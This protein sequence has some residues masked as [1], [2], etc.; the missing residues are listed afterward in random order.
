MMG[1]VCRL[2]FDEITSSGVR[3]ALLADKDKIQGIVILSDEFSPETNKLVRCCVNLPE[4]DS[5]AEFSGNKYP[6]YIASCPDKE[7]CY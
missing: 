1:F 7:G 3:C 6:L 5:E 4:K 2:K